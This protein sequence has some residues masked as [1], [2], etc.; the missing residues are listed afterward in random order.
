M[1]AAVA[2]AGVPV[3]GDI[4]LLLGIPPSCCLCEICLEEDVLVIVI[5]P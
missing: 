4:P 1:A 5:M 2:R 3:I